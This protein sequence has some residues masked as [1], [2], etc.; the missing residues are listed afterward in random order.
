MSSPKVWRSSRVEVRAGSVAGLGL[1][2]REP[3]SRGEV[4]AVKAGHVVGLDEVLRLTKEIEDYSLQIHDDFFLSPRTQAEVDDCVVFINHSC[5]ANIGFE[6]IAYVA[7]RDID[8]DEELCHDYA[9][10]RT[11]P[12]TMGCA[13]DTPVCRGTVTHNDWQLVDVQQRYAGYFMP[14]V[15]RRIAALGR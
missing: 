8:A 13:C 6:G 11:A 2:S 14:H 15:A 1:F 3:I 5:D 9:M 7:I 10:A 12:Y 4:V